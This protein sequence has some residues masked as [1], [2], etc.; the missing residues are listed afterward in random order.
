MQIK[1]K[2]FLI[3]LF[4]TT[5]L[6]FLISGCLGNIGK[7][8]YYLDSRHLGISPGDI[9]KQEAPHKLKV[10]VEFQRNGVHHSPGDN[11]LR[12]V[13]ERVIRDTGFAVPVSDD[14]EGS[15]KIL[16]NNIVNMQE[17]QRRGIAVANGS[18]AGDIS[19]QNYEMDATLII[20]GRVIQKKNYKHKFYSGIGKYTPPQGL[21]DM[22]DSLDL[23]FDKMVEDL[24]L[25]FLKDIQ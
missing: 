15:L 12:D 18:V 3:L 2:W 24:I 13:V 20:E 10:E 8:K 23:V 16:L 21:K 4:G 11:D 25:A 14:E 6:I 17:M 19:A 22:G 7:E 1:L 5:S 9:K